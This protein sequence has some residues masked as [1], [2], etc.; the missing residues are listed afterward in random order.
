MARVNA[1]RFS[2]VGV[3]VMLL[4]VSAVGATVHPAS[5]VNAAPFSADWC[6]HDAAHLLCCYL[7]RTLTFI[8]L[9]DGDKARF[10]LLFAGQRRYYYI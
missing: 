3:G 6:R 10:V 7:A 1:T 8:L 9:I 5:R 2:A 4:I